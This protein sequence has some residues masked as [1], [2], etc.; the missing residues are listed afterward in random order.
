[1]KSVGGILISRERIHGDFP[2][3][4]R[5]RRSIYCRSRRDIIYALR[6]R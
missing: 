6:A 2:D 3:G 5:S 4:T 1:M